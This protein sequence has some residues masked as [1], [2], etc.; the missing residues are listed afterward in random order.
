MKINLKLPTM[1][2]HLYYLF[3]LGF[4]LAAEKQTLDLTQRFCCYLIWKAVH[5]NS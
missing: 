2:P 4:L 1:R 3:L 5:L